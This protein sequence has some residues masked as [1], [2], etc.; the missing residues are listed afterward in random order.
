M[1][2]LAHLKALTER[3]IKKVAKSGLVTV[4]S[5]ALNEEQSVQTAKV[6]VK[7]KDRIAGTDNDPATLNAVMTATPFHVEGG[8]LST[9]GVIYDIISVEQ[10]GEGIELLAQ[11]VVLRER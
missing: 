11:K 8:T 7:I 2:D 3:L 10:S 5:T 1:A 6:Y 9:G 4:T